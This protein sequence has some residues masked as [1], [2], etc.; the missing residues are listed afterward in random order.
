MNG[1][2]YDAG[3]DRLFVTGKNWSKLFEIRVCPRAKWRSR[4]NELPDR[5][6]VWEIDGFRLPDPAGV[7]KRPGWVGRMP[8]IWVGSPQ[9]LKAVGAVCREIRRLAGYGRP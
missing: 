4:G 3:H 5:R 9:A 8:S 7:L 6:L 2:A 1:I